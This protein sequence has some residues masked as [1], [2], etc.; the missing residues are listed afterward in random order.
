[1]NLMCGIVGYFGTGSNIS[2]KLEGKKEV[3]DA[4]TVHVL[5]EGLKRLE[6]RGYDSAGIAMLNKDGFYVVKKEGKVRTLENAI[7]QN[8]LSKAIQ[9]NILP[10]DGLDDFL[11]NNIMKYLGIDAP[12]KVSFYD[13]EQKNKI[14]KQL[15]IT[16]NNHYDM[17]KILSQFGYNPS[18]YRIGLA[19][20]RWATHGV[21]SD[22]NAH[23]HCSMDESVYVVHNGIIENYK[24]LKKSLEDHGIEFKTDTDTEVI[25]QMIYFFYQNSGD[26]EGAVKQ[27]L[28]KLE[29]ANAFLVMHKAYEQ[30][31]GAKFGSSLCLGIMDE[32]FILGSDES[33]FV[34]MTKEVIHLEDND[35]V[36][37]S[38]EYYKGYQIKTFAGLNIPREIREI[39]YDI[40]AIG[41]GNWD[42]YMLKEIHEQSETVKNAFM[43]RI[44]EINS[45]NLDNFVDLPSNINKII[46]LLK[47]FNFCY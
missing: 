28:S 42:H 35:M 12:E 13:E 46:L 8:E 30:I 25:P 41:K 27:T 34:D 15:S 2:K 21:P 45:I 31:I 20:T 32:E 11:Q 10:K 4:T 24:T 14:Y 3:T 23:P 39:P 44:S 40:E 47:F 43:S 29:G 36:I 22:R 16:R 9:K 6:H 26:F 38:K 17:L 37:V 19:H 1:M 7:I 33:P 5:L 18:E